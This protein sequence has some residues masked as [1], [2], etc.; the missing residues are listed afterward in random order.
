MWKEPE[1]LVWL[2]SW[3]TLEAGDVILTGAPGR[4]TK[5]MFLN[6]GDQYTCQ[7]DGLGTLSNPFYT[8]IVQNM[9]KNYV[10]DFFDGVICDS[11]NECLVSSWNAWQTWT[12]RSNFRKRLV[13]SLSMK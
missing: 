9:N 3:I 7:I 11:T 4:I 2:S 12:N 5:R 8:A 13:N 10:F 1:L 6:E